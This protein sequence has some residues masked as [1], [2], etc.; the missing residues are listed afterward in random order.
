MITENRFIFQIFFADLLDL[1]QISDA[2]RLVKA[3][4]TDGFVE[5]PQF[6]KIPISERQIDQQRPLSAST[7]LENSSNG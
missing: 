6:D 3:V 1:G 7:G 2:N 5:R 4:S